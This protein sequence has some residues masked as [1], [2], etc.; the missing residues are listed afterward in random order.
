MLRKIFEIEF[1]HE[2]CNALPSFKM[3]A[4]LSRLCNVKY[5]RSFFAD[6]VIAT[7]LTKA[8]WKATSVADAKEL[9]FD[10]STF[11]STQHGNRTLQVQKK[12]LLVHK[13]WTKERSKLSHYV[14]RFL[15]GL[16]APYVVS[17]V[18]DR[19]FLDLKEDL[20][21]DLIIGRYS[22]VI[23]VDIKTYLEL[24]P[25][26]QQLVRLYCKKFSTGLLFFISN[27]VGVIPEFAI[28]VIKPQKEK[29]T[30]D[31]EVNETSKLLRITRRGGSTVKPYVQ[32]GQGTRWSFL[33]YDPS[34][35]PYET[36]E[37]VVDR[38]KRQ[39]RDLEIAVTDQ[40]TVLLDDGRNDGVK[41][42]FF[43]GGFPFFVHTML[44]MDSLQYLSPVSPTVFSLERYLQIDVDDIFISKS[45]IRMKQKDVMVSCVTFMGS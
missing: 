35:T 39:K 10:E 34:M 9:Y 30:L 44:F 18:D 26:V 29:L 19:P 11:S 5:I 15:D 36:V 21:P 3:A 31:V 41:K 33:R 4:H 13:S 7:E 16:R 43:G 24:K 14:A 38:K 37:Y 28:E 20:K 12:I 8:G 23:F 17:E 27:H 45:G 25:N 22:L 2:N 32:K 6:S 40:A 42:V 1:P